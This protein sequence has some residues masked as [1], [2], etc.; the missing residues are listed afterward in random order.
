L[1]GPDIAKAREAASEAAMRHAAGVLP[2]V[3]PL[4]EAG[5]S[6]RRVAAELTARGVKTACGGRWQAQQVADVLKRA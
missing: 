4:V 6:L 5:W 1:G 2:L 3:K